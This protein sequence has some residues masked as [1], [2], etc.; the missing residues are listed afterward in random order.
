[1]PESTLE[2]HSALNEL[3]IT[4]G[5]TRI[6][7]CP[8]MSIVSISTPLGGKQYL[9]DQLNLAFGIR[10]PATGKV[11]RK[12]DTLALLG[13][14]SDQCFLI[15]N[16]QWPDPVAHVALLLDNCAYLTDQSDSWAALSIKGPLSRSALERVCPIDIAVG[17]FDISCVARTAMEHLSVIIEQPEP[18]TFRLYSP[19]SSAQNFAEIICTSLDHVAIS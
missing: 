13:L 7:E 18:D 6:W 15:G 17:V 10:L 1:M 16:E 4:R 3:S 11:S 9:D 19:R 14:Q 5:D 12:G 2:A 8:P